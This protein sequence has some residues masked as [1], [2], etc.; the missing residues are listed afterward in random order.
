MAGVRTFEEADVLDRALRLFWAH[1]Y[2]GTSIGALTEA[3][4]LS[5][6]SLY[7]AFGDKRGLYLAALD[8]YRRTQA[9]PVL[10]PLTEEADVR[11]ALRR[12]LEGVAEASLKKSGPQPPG[13]FVASAALDQADCN[14][15]TATRVA[16][17][18]KAM[19]GAIQT[20]L[21]RAQAE[22]A[23]PSQKDAQCLAR[24][25]LNV[26]NGLRVTARGTGDEAALQDAIGAALEVLN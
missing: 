26:I 19:A 15:E 2:E 5:R 10:A 20:R 23:L 18:M 12:V 4:G 22:G 24:H 25:F 21:E 7:N 16:E 9:L 3:T 17:S 13:C 8:R 6:S 14:P 11:A 1:G